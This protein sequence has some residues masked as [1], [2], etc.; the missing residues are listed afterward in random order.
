MTPAIVLA[1]SLLV[2]GSALAALTFAV[3]AGRKRVCYVL[4]SVVGIAIL[5]AACLAVP[6]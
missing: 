2:A 6:T 1:A 3:D 5:T 4:I